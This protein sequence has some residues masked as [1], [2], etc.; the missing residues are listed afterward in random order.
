MPKLIWR[1]LYK[2]YYFILATDVATSFIWA[3]S[4]F[5][6]IQD[7]KPYKQRETAAGEQNKVRIDLPTL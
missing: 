1:W 2:H 6:Q 4:T 5:Q 7:K 3:N